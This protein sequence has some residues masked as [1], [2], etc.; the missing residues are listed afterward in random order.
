M[1]LAID[2]P[3]G[4]KF[5]LLRLNARKIKKTQ[6]NLPNFLNSSVVVPGPSGAY[7]YLQR[8]VNRQPGYRPGD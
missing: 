4:R 7:P 6:K 8:A 1:W 3:D 2:D 5:P